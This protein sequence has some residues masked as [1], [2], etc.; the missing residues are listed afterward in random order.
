MSDR[1]GGSD[2]PVIATVSADDDGVR[3][4]VV[5]LLKAILNRV[6]P[7]DLS[8]DEMMA[9]IATLTPAHA[10]VLALRERPTRLTL[11]GKGDR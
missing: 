1:D 10:R 3:A 6:S 4:H 5:W 2:R 7:D 11:V 8:T 9:V